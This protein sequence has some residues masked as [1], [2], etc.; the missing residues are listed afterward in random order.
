MSESVPSNATRECHSPRFTGQCYGGRRSRLSSIVPA[1]ITVKRTLLSPIR[2]IP[3]L[4]PALRAAYLRAFRGEGRVRPITRGP[5]AGM[6]YRKFEWS[7]GEAGMVETNWETDFPD[8]FVREVKA[9]HCL[10]D[11]GANWGFYCLLASRHRPAGARIFAFEAHPRTAR[12]LRAQVRVNAI[13]GAQVLH[14]AIGDREGT[15]EFTDSGGSQVQKLAALAEPGSRTIRVPMWTIDAACAR[16]GA[17]PDLVKIDVEGAEVGVVRG[18]LETLRRH[19]P[20]L[21]IEVHAPEINGQLYDLLHPLG[22]RIF[23]TRGEPV[24]D[25]DYRH[26]VVAR[27][28]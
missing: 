1:G 23:T 19:H 3:V 21:L 28:G 16:L 8:A 11:I 18:G 26:H 2:R 13:S 25:R 17:T 24:A 9:A 7:T 10:W 5:L 20:T 15:I 14:A 6:R 12:Q 22:Y 27:A 4:G